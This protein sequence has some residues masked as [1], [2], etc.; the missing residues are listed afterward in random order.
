[1]PFAAIPPNKKRRVVIEIR[2]PRD[3][4]Q[5]RRLRSALQKLLRQHN[6]GIKRRAAPKKR[7]RR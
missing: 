5:Q 6:A 1:M 3:A 4:A 2:G 7:R